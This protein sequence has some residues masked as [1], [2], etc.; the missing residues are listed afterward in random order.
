VGG[1]GGN[2]A[3]LIVALDGGEWSASLPGCFTPGKG[4]LVHMVD[5][6]PQSPSGHSDKEKITLPL[7]ETDPWLTSL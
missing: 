1:G 6:R 4:P 7:L 2:C 3:F 5:P